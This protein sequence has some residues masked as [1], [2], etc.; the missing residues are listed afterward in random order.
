[1]LTFFK[2]EESMAKLTQEMKDLIAA[3]QCFI[4]TV[5][6]DG[7]PNIGPK[8]STR[9][10]DDEHIAFN[11][12]TAHQTWKNVQNGSKVAIAVV[13]REKLKGFRF[14]GTP[15]AL[16]SGPVFDQAVAMLQKAGVRPLTAVIRVKIEKIFNL[17]LPGAGQEIV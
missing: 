2:R 14:V 13:D 9:V 5:N 8:R 12:V 3:Q 1:M 11:E 6:P 17:G 7:T 4:A 15:E 10:L 16:T